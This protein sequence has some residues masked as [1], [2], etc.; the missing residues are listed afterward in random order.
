MV[1]LSIHIPTTHPLSAKE[2]FNEPSVFESSYDSRDDAWAAVQ[3]WAQ[4]NPQIEAGVLIQRNDGSKEIG[5][6]M[7]NGRLLEHPRPADPNAPEI[8]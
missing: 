1:E 7:K 4:D 3:Q 2:T 8:P 6:I 5:W